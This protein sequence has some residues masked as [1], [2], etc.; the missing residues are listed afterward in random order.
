M[1]VA[2]L[3]PILFRLGVLEPYHGAYGGS[4]AF[5]TH[6]TV[7]TF[8]DFI[9]MGDEPVPQ[10]HRTMPHPPPPTAPDGAELGRLTSPD[11]AAGDA[12]EHARLGQQLRRHVGPPVVPTATISA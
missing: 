9:H 12:R 7:A 5:A 4:P 2:P 8:G 6:S 11:L 3:L 10:Y 1:R